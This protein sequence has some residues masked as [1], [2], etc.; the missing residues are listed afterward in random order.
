MAA[1]LM[2]PIAYS[3]AA[4]AVA[5]CALWAARGLFAQH[6]ALVARVGGGTLPPMAE[7]YFAASGKALRVLAGGSVAAT[8]ADAVYSLAAGPDGLALGL[9]L[10]GAGLLLCCSF[11]LLL[12]A[13]ADMR[14]RLR[15]AAAR[16]AQFG[17]GLVG[18]GVAG[19]GLLLLVQRGA[20]W[21][22]L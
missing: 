16:L 18:F 13:A 15:G 2:P 8:V 11:V 22:V 6:R 12:Q 14:L 10:A 19:L 3:A 20:V 4:L 5:G 9:G 1:D 7:L 17:A 21:P